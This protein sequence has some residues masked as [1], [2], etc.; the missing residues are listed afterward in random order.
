MILGIGS[1]IIE[2]NRIENAIENTKGFLQKVFTEEEKKLFLKKSMR[3]ETIAGNFAVKEAVS[4]AL[5]TGIRGF[6]L[7]DIEV[8]RNDLGKPVVNLYNNALEIAK[9]LE[10][11]NIHVSISHNKKDAIAYVVLEGR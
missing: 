2:I 6:S 5:G 10:V 8:L 7:K 9:S 11:K 3:S 1:D 4:K